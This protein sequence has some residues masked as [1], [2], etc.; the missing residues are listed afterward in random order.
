MEASRLSVLWAWPC[1]PHICSLGCLPP[2]PALSQLASVV[3]GAN[4]EPGGGLELSRS[5][6]TN[7]RS[8]EG[9]GRG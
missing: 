4:G 8:G 5:E 1:I 3:S 7:L 9:P 6:S 2:S